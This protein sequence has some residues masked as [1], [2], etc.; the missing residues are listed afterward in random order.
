M[1][2]HGGKTR[3]RDFI[4]NA[5]RFRRVCGPI[6]T[7]SKQWLHS[8]GTLYMFPEAGWLG[9]QGEAYCGNHIHDGPTRTGRKIAGARYP[10]APSLT[11]SA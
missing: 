11:A 10:T 5:G 7:R 2:S 8:A 3:V 4:V 1:P 9:F 6:S